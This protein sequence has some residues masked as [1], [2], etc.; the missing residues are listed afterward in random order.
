MG[1]GLDIS[2]SGDLF[3]AGIRLPKGKEPELPLPRSRAKRAFEKEAAFSED[4][5]RSREN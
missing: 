3:E 5:F 1:G 4:R 2:I